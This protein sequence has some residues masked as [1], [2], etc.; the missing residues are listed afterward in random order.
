[1]SKVAF[2]GLGEEK[3]KGILRYLIDGLKE[4]NAW[5]CLNAMETFETIVPRLGNEMPIL[6]EFEEEILDII[7]GLVEN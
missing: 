7:D 6:D 1:M 2:E 4:E 3:I 5:V